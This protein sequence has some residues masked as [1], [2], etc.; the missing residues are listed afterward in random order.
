MTDARTIWSSDSRDFVQF[1]GW[2]ALRLMAE[3]GLD[4]GLDDGLEDWV[5]VHMGS[6]VL[7]R[8]KRL[9]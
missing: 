8:S 6:A 7:R 2:L 1:A 9:G 5:D 3:V 4:G